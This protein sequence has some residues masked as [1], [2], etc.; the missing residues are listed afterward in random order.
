MSTL[1]MKP[2]PRRAVLRGLGTVLGLPLLDAMVPI[3]SAAKA[4]PAP[5]HRLG[6]LYVPN[7]IQLVN[8]LPRGEGK[9][10]EVTPILAPLEKFRDRMVVVSGLANAQADPLNL[11]SG[12]HTR[13]ASTWL[14]GVRPRH[15]EGADIES[16]TTVDQHAAAKIGDDTALRSLQLALDPTYTVGNCEGGYSCAYI[17]TFS[18]RTPTAP[19]PMETSPRQV[20]ERLFGAE[21][22]VSGR[23]AQARRNRS[24]LDS[25][26]GDIR[27]LQLE[28]GPGDRGTVNEFT[29]AVRDV[30]RRLQIVE[31]NANESPS[32]PPTVPLSI[33]DSFEEH[34]NLMFELQFLA[35]RADITRVVSFQISRE[36]STRSYPMLGVA[37]AHHDI[38]HHGNN[39]E[40]MAK[41]T[42]INTYH[43]GLFAGLVERMAATQDGDGSLLDHSMLLYGAGMGD[44]SIHSPHNLPVV[45]VG[46]GCGQLRGG[47]HVK[48]PIDT[49]MMNLGLS[50]LDKVGVHLD[51]LG[52]ST[53]RLADL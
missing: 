48:C 46:G 15:S 35:Y 33:P 37:E 52:D 29:Q 3:M 23:V 1:T 47:R 19:L 14:N 50:F 27:R 26:T 7:G 20:F 53:G 34:A 24:I 8:F 28:L 31:L 30:E 22:S 41:N 32:R 4:A 43:M 45:I 21:G 11:S 10:L 49:P 5:V 40:K 17:N 38:S 6:F 9:E 36:L 18:W 16:G 39:P 12:A 44:G 2:L 51:R 42:K 13:A 25:V